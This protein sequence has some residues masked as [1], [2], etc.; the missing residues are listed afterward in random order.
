MPLAPHR[1][2]TDDQLEAC[3]AAEWPAPPLGSELW[4]R[5]GFDVF[6]FRHPG[7][8]VGPDAP[9]SFRWRFKDRALVGFFAYGWQ[10]V[11]ARPK[12]KGRRG[13][14]GPSMDY[15]IFDND[16]RDI[17]ARKLMEDGNAAD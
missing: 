1:E 14:P 6:D 15:A 2:L 17:E 11:A 7:E 4:R 9:V 8:Q 10:E 13:K 12:R 5:D 16:R 3:R